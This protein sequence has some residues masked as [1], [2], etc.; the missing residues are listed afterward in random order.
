MDFSY[1]EDQQA[2]GE[3]ARQILADNASHEALRA[4]ETSG[5]PRFDL[6]LWKKLAESGLLGLGIDESLGGAGMG[7]VETALV[8]TQ[9]GRTAA[10]CP[11]LETLVLGA[12]PVA[13][14]GSD[15]LRIRLLP[16]VCEGSTVLTAAFA[17]EGDDLSVFGRP[18][19]R[20][21][22]RGDGWCLDGSKICVPYGQVADHFVVPA[23][24]GERSVGVFVVDARADGVA[25]EP[26]ATTN[27][28][29][30][31]MLHLSA[32]DVGPDQLLGDGRDGASIVDWTLLRATAAY[33]AL[34]LGVCERALELTSE[35]V[36]TRK[37]F[38]QPIGM[39]Q[40]VGHRAADAYIDTEAIRL[41]SMQACWRIDAGRPAEREVAVAKF[42]A[43][44]GGQRVV[45]AA[46][47]L[48]GGVGVDREYPLHRCFL[49]AK[50]LELQL[51]GATPQLLRLG[52]LLAEDA[53]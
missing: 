40:A 49:W 25:T 9:I 21:A 12:L 8:I 45:H 1:G 47:H 39:F 36:K 19:T 3:L 50:H 46:Q 5:R 2:I 20:A 43:A 35:Y 7:L 24:T 26:V 28:Q 10:P 16:A 11:V 22:R 30:D 6:G 32:V 34:A 44:E 33:S 17:E 14:F 48:H 15:A 13:E 42:W 29:P 23:A 38:G 18:A 53:A 41:T 52:R 27:G 4:L 51:G 37:Q 31:A